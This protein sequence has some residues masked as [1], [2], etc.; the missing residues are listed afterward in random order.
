MR[1]RRGGRGGTAPSLAHPP[2]TAEITD[3]H[4]MSRPQPGERTAPRDIVE[5]RALARRQPD[6]AAAATLHAELAATVRRVGSRLTT[7]SLDIPTELL[8]ARLTRRVPL[9]SFGEFPIDWPEARLLVRQVTDSLHRVDVVDRESAARLHAAGRDASL[10][11][12]A[13]AWYEASGSAGADASDDPDPMW[14]EVLGWA[15]KPFL[16]RTAEVLTRRVS[17]DAWRH[18]RCPVCAAEPELG[19]ILAGGDV[20]LLCSRCLARWPFDGGCAYCEQAVATEMDT[21][22]TADR[23]YRVHR[24]RRCDRYLKLLDTQA[25]G[26][27]L[28]PFYDPVASLPLDAALMQARR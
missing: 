28:L 25:A 18:G 22:T 4:D 24:C 23:A 3:N 13:R 5:L 17:L 12:R 19:A 9:A 21:M 20:T 2:A 11:D 26:R 1:R 15:L 10:P 6:L 14:G 8:Q 27:P 16:M 7:P